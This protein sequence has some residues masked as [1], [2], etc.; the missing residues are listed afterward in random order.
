MIEG[1]P[2]AWRPNTIFSNG[3]NDLTNQRVYG[4][5]HFDDA[6]VSPE[7]ADIDFDQKQVI[8]NALQALEDKWQ[9]R[10]KTIK[11]K[12]PG[13]QKDPDEVSEAKSQKAEEIEKSNIIDKV[14]LET[15]PNEEIIK[16]GKDDTL[17][18]KK[19]D[20][21]YRTVVVDGVTIKLFY[22]DK[23]GPEKRYF[24]YEG[25]GDNEISII[26]NNN[27]PRISEVVYKQYIDEIVFDALTL[28][29]VQM[30]ERITTEAIISV[31]DSL[32]RSNKVDE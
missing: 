12:K 17:Q 3:E 29:K 31:K 7:K 2:N 1:N 24:E 10:K 21:S 4:E 32:M 9:L 30:K 15:I 22:G 18:I 23:Y 13:P 25:T 19:D 8:D 20:K 6:I 16:I 26:I 14:K 28:W 5:I 27:H 11:E